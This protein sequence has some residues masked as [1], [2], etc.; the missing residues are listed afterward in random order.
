MYKYIDT[1]A[2][3]HLVPDMFMVRLCLPQHRHTQYFF[4][5]ESVI[6]RTPTTSLKPVVH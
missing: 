1:A 5:A 2:F 3:M 6:I 4:L